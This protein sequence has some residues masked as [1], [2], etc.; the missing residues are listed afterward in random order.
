M[1]ALAVTGFAATANAANM[2]WYTT[3]GSTDLTIEMNCGESLQVPI[4][5]M[6]QGDT[7]LAGWGL[8]FWASEDCAYTEIIS[9]TQ[10]VEFDWVPDDQ[11]YGAGP[12]LLY[13]GGTAAVL[14]TPL[15]DVSTPTM[16][17]HMVIEIICPPAPCDCWTYIT[18]TVNQ[19]GFADANYAIPYVSFMGGE[20]VYAAQGAAAGTVLSI[21]CV[22]EPGTLVLLGLGALA[23]IRRR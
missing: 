12:H 14:E 17:A 7:G 9:Y 6:Y 3:G 10:D 21:H 5:I 18:A 4:E 11:A 1:V 23:L 13:N 2:C 15:A 8:D 22:P 19:V 20:A 16:L